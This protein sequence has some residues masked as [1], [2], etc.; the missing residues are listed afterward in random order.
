MAPICFDNMAKPCA[1]AP[2]VG[3]GIPIVVCKSLL[4]NWRKDHCNS[5]WPVSFLAA[6]A[7]YFGICLRQPE[8]KIHGFSLP[9]ILGPSYTRPP[10]L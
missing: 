7:Q 3:G 10:V 4:V 1:G 9:R 6:S 2:L 5:S 8:V